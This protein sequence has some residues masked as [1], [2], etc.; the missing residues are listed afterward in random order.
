MSFLEPLFGPSQ[1]E[2]WRQLAA[3]AGG[4]L[5]ERNFWHGTEVRAQVG[6]WTLTLD[7]SGGKYPFTRL[8]APYVNPEGFHFHVYRGSIFSGLAKLLGTQDIVVGDPAFDQAFMVKAT[9]PQRIRD[10]LTPDLRAR[11]MAHPSLSLQ[12]KDDEGLF[13]ETFPHGVDELY[14]ALPGIEKDLALLKD[15]F[16]LFGATLHRLCVIGSAYAAPPGF[17]L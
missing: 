5:K 15:A 9:D 16:D 14:M 11:L 6:A 17:K 12:V 4:T 8:R 10:L 13:G 1:D 2:L 7:V 3:Q